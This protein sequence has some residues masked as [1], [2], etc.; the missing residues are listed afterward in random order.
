MYLEWPRSKDLSLSLQLCK[1]SARLVKERNEAATHLC[2]FGAKIDEY[3]L[4][5]RQL[6]D[7]ELLL[8]K[9][10]FYRWYSG[11]R[12][13]GSIIRRS[14]HP[15]DIS[16]AINFKP[17]PKVFAPKMHRCIEKKDNRPEFFNVFLLLLLLWLLYY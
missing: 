14:H 3:H 7:L 1:G 16:Y 4:P 6:H 15:Q 17:E 5:S 8:E 12:R 13:N 10:Q 11:C 9:Q 2:E